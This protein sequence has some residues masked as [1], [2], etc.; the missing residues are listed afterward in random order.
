MFDFE[1]PLVEIKTKIEELKKISSESGMDLS[2][3]IEKFEQQA[4]EY[5]QEIYS[6]L[7]PSEKLQIARHA[8]RPSFLDY[9]ESIR[10]LQVLSIEDT[11]SF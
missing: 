5:Q 1:K 3:E 11:R 6:N 8:N 7:K 2:K 9:M 10:V 4:D